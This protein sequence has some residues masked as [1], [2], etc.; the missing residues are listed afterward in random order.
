MESS[1]QARQFFKNNF[2][3]ST[4]PG[5][6]G[7]LWRVPQDLKKPTFSKRSNM[8]HVG[9]LRNCLIKPINFFKKNCVFDLTRSPRTK[10]YP[11]TS[12]N[13][14]SQNE[15]TCGMWGVYGIVSLCPLKFW[16]FFALSTS[17]G[18]QGPLRLVPQDL[19]KPTFS[20]WSNMWQMWYQRNRSLGTWCGQ[21]CKNTFKNW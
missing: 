21:K 17:P 7:P 12:K 11:R 15:A 1:C 18:T 5:P 10:G 2:A 3:F 8:W 16:F 20:K 6:Q 4:S 19:Q 9:C 13:R 14:L